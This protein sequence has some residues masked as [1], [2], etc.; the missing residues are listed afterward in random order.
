[1]ETDPF[2]IQRSK[3]SAAPHAPGYEKRAETEEN[4]GGGLGHGLRA[5]AVCREEVSRG[6]DPGPVPAQAVRVLSAEVPL[7]SIGD[8]RPVIDPEG[9]RVIVGAI[10]LGTRMFTN[11]KT[12]TL[13]VLPFSLPAERVRGNRAIDRP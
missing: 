5:A 12:H 2:E 6:P 4:R 10:W 3:R 13:S 1:M 7:R 8:Q 9:P 11:P